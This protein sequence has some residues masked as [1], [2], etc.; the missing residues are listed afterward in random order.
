[1][2][3]TGEIIGEWT[4]DRRRPSFYGKFKKRLVTLPPGFFDE[5]LPAFK[6]V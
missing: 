5:S 1:M 6:D 4:M 2:T 3:E